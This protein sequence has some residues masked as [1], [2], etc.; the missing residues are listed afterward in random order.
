MTS[1]EWETSLP[2]YLR[3]GRFTLTIAA[4]ENA[5]D[6]EVEVAVEAIVSIGSITQQWL[7]RSSISVNLGTLFIAGAQKF[8][9]AQLVWP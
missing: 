3:C 1:F 5:V 8:G 2:L 9:R 7:F 4:I 6:A